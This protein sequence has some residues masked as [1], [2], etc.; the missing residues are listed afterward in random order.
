M[1]RNGM[2]LLLFLTVFVL[3]LQGQEMYDHFF[4]EGKKWVYEQRVLDEDGWHD[5]ESSI[6]VKGDTVIDGERYCKT[7]YTDG[8]RDTSYLYL[9]YR[10]EN[11]QVFYRQPDGDTTWKSYDFNIAPGDINL[12]YQ[13]QT[14]KSDLLVKD[15]D[16]VS[17]GENTFQRW[18]FF[19]PNYSEDIDQV[20][21]Y[22]I[23]SDHFG[24]RD[25]HYDLPWVV[26]GS[27]YPRIVENFKACY[28]NGQCVF[29]S[30]DFWKDFTT[31]ID[32][33]LIGSA[34]GRI[35]LDKV[36]DLQGR[37]VGQG[38]NVTE[39][40]GNKLPKGIYIQNGRKFVIK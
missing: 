8:Y 23:G 40:Q 38:N 34:T 39:Y 12:L 25:P 31:G 3:R 9:L 26:D 4:S 36:Y 33:Q 17:V 13:M 14:G 35:S 28:E 19:Y 2:L 18:S 32:A 11:R 7:Y 30:A 20:W 27:D 1:K 21:V 15:V 37:R 6:E 5:E 16:E 29:Q 24:I 22:G 10:E